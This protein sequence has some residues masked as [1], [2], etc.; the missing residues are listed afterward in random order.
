MW[1]AIAREDALPFLLHILLVF[2]QVGLLLDETNFTRSQ[3]QK[4]VQE[5]QLIEM[6]TAGRYEIQSLH[7]SLNMSEVDEAAPPMFVMQWGGRQTAPLSL[8]ELG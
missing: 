8:S 1:P 3:T 2:L 4:V 6:S 7:V 5:R